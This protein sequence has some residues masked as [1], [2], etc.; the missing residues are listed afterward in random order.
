M[1]TEIIVRYVLGTLGIVI[2][3][4]GMWCERKR[5][6]QVGTAATQQR[7]RS[8]PEALEIE[9]HLLY[10]Q[11][12]ATLLG[13]RVHA[14]SGNYLA[15]SAPLSINTNVHGTSFAG[16][17]Y[18]VIVLTCYYATRS[19]LLQQ[20][21]LQ[22]YILVAKSAKIQYL[23]PVTDC[24]LIVARCILPSQEI[25][26][27]FRQDLVSSKQKGYLQVEGKVNLEGGSTACECMVELCAYKRT[28]TD[29]WRK[30]TKQPRDTQARTGILL[31][32][33]IHEFD[34]NVT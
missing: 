9:Q 15:L 3:L 20:S 2:F 26:E 8:N 1:A 28:T 4:L 30:C 21:E 7:H 19:W 29:W 13:I 25:L 32:Q 12:P 24:E 22:D 11:K 23:Y 31:V 33:P 14:C 17:L 10:N 27:T 18:S 34:M 16:S 5:S 6:R